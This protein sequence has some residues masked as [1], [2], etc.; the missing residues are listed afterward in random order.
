MVLVGFE[1]SSPNDEYPPLIFSN[2]INI[3]NN[4]REVMTTVTGGV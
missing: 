2:G 4:Y 3:S 1:L